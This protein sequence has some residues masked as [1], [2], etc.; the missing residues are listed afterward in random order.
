MEL[1]KGSW[2][3]EAG[4]QNVLTGWAL[5]YLLKSRDCDMLAQQAL[6]L[7]LTQSVCHDLLSHPFPFGRTPTSAHFDCLVPPPCSI[8]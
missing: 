4:T 6:L 2:R 8:L 5:S 3:P 1:D 7:Y